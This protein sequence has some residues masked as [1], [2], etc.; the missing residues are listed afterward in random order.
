M[1]KK[2]K[3]DRGY[4]NLQV[5]LA[6]FCFSA[7]MVF[8]TTYNSYVPLILDSKLRDLGAIVLPV[9]LISTLTGF[10]MT[11]DNIFGLIF[12][13]LYGRRSD[14]MRSKW[15][16]R[17][18]YLLVGVPSC[19]VLFALIPQAAKVPGLAG[20]L[21]MMGCII[22]FNF[23]MS[24]WRA[25]CVSIMPDMVPIKYQGDANAIV[26]IT[27]S[28]FTI[29]IGAVPALLSKAGLKQQIDGGDYSS[30]FLASSIVCMILIGIVLLTVHFNDNRNEPKKE[31]SRED[32][33]KLLAIDS[34][35]LDPD[36]KRSM[37]IMMMALFCISGGND[38]FGT[39]YTL[40]ATKVLGIASTSA[41]LIKTIGTIAAAPIAIFAGVCGR[42]FGR[43]RTV[44]IGLMISIIAYS[45]MAIMTGFG[46]S[47]YRYLLIAFYGLMQF[48]NGLTTFNT[49][50]IML[51]IGGEERFG[52]FT[53]Y[54]YFGT[55]SAA[56]VCPT[57]IGWLVGT[58]GGEK[59]AV[60]FAAAI[61]LV[62]LALMT[63]VR[64]GEAPVSQDALEKAQ[65]MAD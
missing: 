60:V 38:G 23:I 40:F 43:R 20:I 21:L 47:D 14:N 26:N 64:H 57:V 17:M 7:C 24:T 45:M 5:I 11:I 61:S 29:I 55:F 8:W 65:E 18:P 49:L 52:A 42:R 41:S 53:G 31:I 30:I 9:T 50:P 22:V 46:L 33:R 32:D 37:I 39:Y 10:I 58:F 25:P 56:V 1:T 2:K 51:A 35:G 54:Y 6:S 16:K 63:R 62:G 12:Q 15:G 34:L 36:V 4:S 13:P 19:A 28:V 48:G 3:N 59:A 44:M 27:S